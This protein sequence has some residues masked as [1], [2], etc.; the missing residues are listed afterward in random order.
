MSETPN[1][2]KVYQCSKCS[3]IERS[4]GGIKHVSKTCVGGRIRRIDKT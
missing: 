2:L 4:V 1:A 3:H